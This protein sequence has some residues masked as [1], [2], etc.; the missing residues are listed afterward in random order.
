MMVS[1]A[2]FSGQWVVIYFYPKDD[3]PGCTKESCGFSEQYEH[4]SALNATVIGISP[5]GAGAHQQFIAKV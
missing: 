4:F 1:L 5:D 3:T 2:D